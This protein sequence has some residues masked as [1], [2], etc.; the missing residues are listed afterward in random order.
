MPGYVLDAPAKDELPIVAIAAPFNPNTAARR[1]SLV[2]DHLAFAIDE[3]NNECYGNVIIYIGVN[4]HLCCR[5][6][7]LCLQLPD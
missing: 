7:T 6:V 5:W 1:L 2:V 3:M 4:G